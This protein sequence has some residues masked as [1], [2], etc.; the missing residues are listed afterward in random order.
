MKKQR[1]R[2]EAIVVF[3]LLLVLGGGI[4]NSLTLY[5]QGHFSFTATAFLQLP[6]S[7][8]PNRVPA[9]AL[10]YRQKFLQPKAGNRDSITFWYTD[11]VL[12]VSYKQNL[13]NIAV[14]GALS[15][16]SF[17]VT[18]QK[19]L[20]QRIAD[21]LLYAYNIQEVF[22]A[23]DVLD[24]L[25]RVS[26]ISIP[27]PQ[28]PL[29]SIFGKPT[30][31]LDVNGEVNVRAGWRWDSQSLGTASA[32]GQVQSGPIFSQ[33]IQINV[34]GK[35]GDKLNLGVDWNTRRQF[36][37]DNKFKIGFDGEDDD[38][39][40]KVEAGNVQFVTPATL[41]GSSQALFG[42]AADFQFGPVFLK[43]IASQKRG[44][45][46]TVRVRGGATRQR[47]VLHAYDYAENHFF[48]DTAYKKVYQAYFRYSTPVIPPEAASLRIKDIEVWESTV[49]VKEAA[50]QATEAVA[51][52]DLPPI[53]V[54]SFY[55]PALKRVKIS[56]GTAGNIERGKFVRLNE[57]SYKYDPNLG[58][59]T[60]YNLRRDRTYAVAYRIEGQTNAKED[61][62]I[63]GT[64][65]NMIGE[66]DTLILRLVYRP[67]MQPAFRSIWERQ[68]RNIYALGMSNVS[69]ENTDIRILYIRS[70]NDSSDV[71]EGTQD[72]IVT[73]L[74][75]DQRNNTSGEPQPDGLFDINSGVF[76]DP[77][78]GE[79]IFPDLEPFRKRLQEYFSQLGT[80]QLADQYI[81]PAV[82]D[83]TKEI[84]RL[85]IERDR[86]LIVADV[87]GV[88]GN[89]IVL[90]GAFNLTPGSVRVYLDGA[91]LQEGRDY[92]V[93]YFSGSVRLLNP[94]ATLPNANIE[95]EYEQNDVFNLSTRTLLG[96]RADWDMK[97]LLRS[98]YVQ[99]TLGMTIMGY[100]QSLQVD[101]V[102][103]GDEPVSNVMFGFDGRLD[104]KAPWLTDALRKIPLFSNLSA[105]S[106]FLLR[107]EWAMM[108][109][110]PNKRKSDVVSDQGESVAYLDNF[111]GAERNIYLGLMPE[112]WQYSSPPVDSSIAETDSAAALYRGQLYWYRYFIGRTPYQ[113]VY[114]NKDVAPGNQN[115][116]VLRITFTPDIRGIYNYN[117]E[118][119]DT[120][121]PVFDPLIHTFAVDNRHRIWGGMMRLLSTYNTNFDAENI[122]YIEIMMK[123]DEK[124]PGARMFI[125][126][127]QISEDVIPNQRLN[128]E[129]G[130]TEANPIPNGILDD[131]E[132]VGL[133]QWNDEQE[134]ANVPYPLNLEAD[135]SR[136]N[137]VFDFDKT[138]SAQTEQDFVA[139]N[140]FEGNGQYIQTQVPD[141]EVLNPNN[142][143]TILLD[144]SYFSYEVN[145]DDN[146]SRN[147]QI[148]GGGS[149]GWYLYRIPIRTGYRKVGNPSFSNIQYVRIWFKGGRLRLRIADWVLAGSQ[150]RKAPVA[151]VEYDSVLSISFVNR[152]ENSGPPDYYTLPPGVRP[153]RQ[154]A[155]P[156]P[157]QELFLNEQSLSISVKQLRFGEQRMA[158]RY[159][160]NTQDLFNYRWMKVFFHGDGTMPDT[161]YPGQIPSAI[162]FIR[163]GSDSLNYY[164]VRRPLKRDWQELAIDLRKLTAIKQIRDS[165]LLFERQEFADPD[166]PQI[167]YVIRGNPT[168]TAVRFVGF[169]LENPKERFP[170]T[171]TTTLWVDELRLVGAEDSPDWA[172]VAYSEFNLAEFATVSASYN[173]QQ[174]NFHR[175]E[176]RFGDRIN[177]SQ[178]S[179][180]VRTQVEKLLPRSLQQFSIPISL[181]HR[182][183]FE[184]PLYVANNDVNLEEAAQAA[185]RKALEQGAT[186][187]EAQR[188]GEEVR[189]RSQTLVVEDGIALTGLR[190]AIPSRFWLIR[191]VVNRIGMAFD[192]SQQYERSPIVKQRFRW[193]WNFALNYSVT[194]PPNYRIFPLRWSKSIPVLSAFSDWE[195]SLLPTTFSTGI[196][197]QRSRQTEQSR[198]LASPSPVIRTFSANRRL[199][200]VWNLSKNGLLNPTLD[201]NF[202]GYSSL[203][204]Y[205]VDASGRQQPFS[206]ILDRMF[207]ENNQILNLGEDYRVVQTVTLNFRPR[208][209]P[210]SKTAERFLTSTGAF[211]TTYT[212]ESPLQKAL[213]LENIVK[214]SSWN[215]TINFGVAFRLKNLA[216]ELFGTRQQQ[217]RLIP[218]RRSVSAQQQEKDTA[219]Q[220]SIGFF[221]SVAKVLRTLFLDYENITWN[222]RQNNSAKNTGVIGGSGITNLLFR[223][224]F[225]RE[226]SPSFG[227][228]AAYQLGLVSTPHGGFRIASSSSFPFFKFETYPGIRPPN[229]VLL[230]NFSQQTSIEM[231]T[232]RPLWERA[233][234]DLQWRSSFS[235]NRN[236]TITTDAFGNP[237]PSNI[238]VTQ[239][240]QRTFFSLP[241]L[242]FPGLGLNTVED[243]VLL[244]QQQKAVIENQ[245]F[246]TATKNQ[247]LAQALSDAFLDGM[248]ALPWLPRDIR[249][250]L[251]RVNWAIRWDGLEKL[252]FW[253]KWVQSARLEHR[254]VSE[255]LENFRITD[256]GKTIEA[257]RITAGFD[258]LISLTAQFYQDKL[259]GILTA[260]LRFSARSEYGITAGARSTISRSTTREFSL[261]ARYNRRGGLRIPWFNLN[262]ENELEVSL[263]ASVQQ[264]KR[265][266]YDVTDFNSEDG[267]RIDGTT[268]ILIEPRARYTLS[269]RV[270]ATFFFRHESTINEG[271]TQPG[272]STTQVGIDLRISVSGGL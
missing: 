90:P 48:L 39:I 81:Y 117:P 75:V 44:N 195:L 238:V 73:I 118:F 226:Q 83:T 91:P 227:P 11:T 258:P 185:E 102:Q 85:Q 228:S 222:F 113:E 177:R 256:N 111:E 12:Y 82:Y 236:Q 62:Q 70:S 219:K 23:G 176:E 108:V 77:Q 99:S 173:V 136:D 110:D 63:V 263:V 96:L 266:T 253:S 216:D 98:R 100:D 167:T 129:D 88:S 215:N 201:Y 131:G 152:E 35:V 181:S 124:E 183:S 60:I 240:Y 57:Q 192:Y 49:D 184:N 259:D 114:P 24:L 109:P 191:D 14:A 46:K 141:Q 153:P 206:T 59:L 182:E 174:P 221:Q 244:Y 126:L 13:G 16:D 47:I 139:F 34:S 217:P 103:L 21:S 243:V 156:D 105:P 149:N 84:A 61:D 171:L 161:I 251:P 234:L 154:L 204:P 7:I 18:R 198:Y 132:D 155:N 187:E 30:I 186:P 225:G 160:Y 189:Q 197:L 144:N 143:Q 147:P 107:G 71:L 76:F 209:F 89:R 94:R 22:Q 130:I 134:K 245:N 151:G 271:A 121:N 31:T 41:I 19:E 127:G 175:L 123:I 193:L 179:I 267:R 162:A 26:T 212:W 224:P 20:Q 4:V 5:G 68:M 1:I 120:L 252:P 50:I 237:T 163:F 116:S 67:N 29:S 260:T 164:E 140:R 40:K 97:T 104:V 180:A 207:W 270:T 106:N 135:P 72:K 28:N 52:A 248:E 213:E 69:I 220:Q 257:Q 262:L 101:Q 58:T 231:R 17:L 218:G 53:P 3:I 55:D 38:I 43:T 138:P 145:L 241:P 79:I 265:A 137:F 25:R 239:S 166:N 93:E 112:F 254:Y 6:D 268:R 272:I 54:G 200:F 165:L 9:E 146:P 190:I 74:R 246:D 2:S 223:A 66:K 214:Q 261:Q 86:F 170:N 172:A 168:L 92:T 95:I 235:Y 119:L 56:Q 51:Y 27:I 196:Q 205:E 125:D 194:I 159:F 45:R 36:E 249:K 229:A 42:V 264:S 80:P 233:T 148:V 150:W 15:V 8:Y 230:D 232:S 178:L 87:T 242:L 133:D 65:S 255:Y 142:G 199:Q 122:E 208:L 211:T 188:I 10:E 203:V 269:R 247:A 37:F 115:F 158:I 33:D 250:V 169:G 32:F 202:N 78:R 157:L 210:F 128:T 64:F